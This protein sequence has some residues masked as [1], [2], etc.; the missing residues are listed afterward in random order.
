TMN[1]AMPAAVALAALAP[2]A[3]P[4][5]ARLI[6]TGVGVVGGLARAN[7]FDARRRS[8]SVAAPLV[9]LVG[10]V[11]GNAAAANSFTESGI[12]ERRREPAPAA[13]PGP[14]RPA[15]AGTDPVVRPPRRRRGPGRRPRR[16][17]SPRYRRRSGRVAEGWRRHAHRDQRQGHGDRDGPGWPVRPA[18]RGELGGDRGRGA[19]ARV[20]RGPD[21]RP[22]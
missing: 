10:L 17:G 14:G 6:P 16:A 7:L 19:A 11:L 15:R 21:H 18:R 5:V 4:L 13:R 12:G 22:D 9:V 8:A 20:R 2:L 3:V 1:V